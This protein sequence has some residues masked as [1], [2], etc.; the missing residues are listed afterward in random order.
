MAIKQSF[1]IRS[2]PI[3]EKPEIDLSSQKTTSVNPSSAKNEPLTKPP[4]LQDIKTQ[5]ERL[6]MPS[7]LEKAK[8]QALKT[9]EAMAMSKLA[10]Q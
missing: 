5:E 7:F 8:A 3:L 4:L 1:Q 2:V 6:K 10:N 9:K